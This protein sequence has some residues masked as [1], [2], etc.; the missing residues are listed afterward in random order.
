M[1]RHRIQGV[2]LH[3]LE[4]Q[5]DLTRIGRAAAGQRHAVPRA[6]EQRHPQ[7]GLERGDLARHCALRQAQG[8]GGARVAFV[9]GRGIEAQQ[10][11]KGGNL[12]THRESAIPWTHICLSIARLRRLGGIARIDP[13]DDREL[14]WRLPHGRQGTLSLG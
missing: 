6:A 14:F 13:V 4:P 7:E 1:V 2:A 8:L 5:A 9:P 12:S 11:L 10:G 3:R